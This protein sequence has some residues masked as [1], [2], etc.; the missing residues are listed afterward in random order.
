VQSAGDDRIGES[1]V[2][3]V[4]DD[5]AALRR[6]GAHAAQKSVGVLRAAA[7]SDD[8]LSGRQ[9]EE[10]LVA[11]ARQRERIVAHLDIAPETIIG[12]EE[13]LR[14]LRV[15]VGRRLAARA[16]ESEGGET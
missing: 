5:L 9:I 10:R 13:I 1:A 2:R 7:S 15:L 8:Q 12:D 16:E 4:N 11:L 14:R 6:N 3:G